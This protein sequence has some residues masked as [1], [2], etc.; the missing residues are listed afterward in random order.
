MKLL[1]YLR[2]R[3]PVIHAGRL[4]LCL[5]QGWHTHTHHARP[6]NGDVPDPKPWLLRLCFVRAG[7][8]EGPTKHPSWN[9][10]LYTRWGAS[11]NHFAIKPR[12]RSC[13]RINW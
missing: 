13:W 8:I 3:R 5:N 2:E 6:Y 1:A 9:L 7:S 11:S 4:M 10:W 12:E